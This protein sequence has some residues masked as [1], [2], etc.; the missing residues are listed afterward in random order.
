MEA[1]VTFVIAGLMAS[2]N[3]QKPFNPILG[4]TY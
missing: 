1:V 2:V 4:E 3:L